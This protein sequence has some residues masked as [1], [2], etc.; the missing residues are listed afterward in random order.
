MEAKDT[1]QQGP[2]NLW[3]E[4]RI[5]CH[6]CD[7]DLTDKEVQYNKDLKCWEPCMNCW[8]VIL[9]AAYSDGFQY[10]DS[11]LDGI[12]IDPDFDV[13]GDGGDMIPRGSP[14]GYE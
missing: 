10:D 1:P 5:K 8:D 14:E 9:D 13:Y 4:L 12:V 11:E 3:K 2:S 7:K 6:I